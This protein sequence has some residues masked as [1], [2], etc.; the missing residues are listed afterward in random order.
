M[1]FSRALKKL[2]LDALFMST[3]PRYFIGKFCQILGIS[4]L[5]SISWESRQNSVACCILPIATTTATILWLSGLSLGQPGWAGTRR[6]IHPLTPIM[7]IN[8]PYLLPPSFTIHG[9]LLVQFMHMTVFYHNLSPSFLW[10][11][12]WPGTLHFILHTFLYT[13]IVFFLQHMLI[14]S[15]PVLLCY[16]NYSSNPSLSLN[17]LLGTLS[18]SLNATHPSDHSHLCLLKCHLIFL[19]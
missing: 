1:S 8:I 13:I 16:R 11:V 2:W 18:C 14:P 7:V 6:N 3:G 4:K 9:I 19:S 15:Q 5:H 17:P 10:S 12:F